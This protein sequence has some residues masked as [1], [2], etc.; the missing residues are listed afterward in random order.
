MDVLIPNTESQFKST[1][2]PA[3]IP[4]GIPHEVEAPDQ[5]ILDEEHEAPEIR[6]GRHAEAP[7][8][9]EGRSHSLEHEFTHG[10]SQ[11]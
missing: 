7:D 3:G 11:S 10:R 2:F 9:G 1:P 6:P 8:A 4:G 5:G